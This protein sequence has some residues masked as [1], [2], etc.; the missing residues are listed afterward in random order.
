MQIKKKYARVHTNEIFLVLNNRQ[1]SFSLCSMNTTYKI[2][3]KT[4]FCNILHN[5]EQ[6]LVFLRSENDYSPL[7]PFVT[8]I[9]TNKESI[10]IIGKLPITS[11]F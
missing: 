9:M 6:F 5:G 7:L 10:S 2:M 4:R 8:I 1:I 3:Y 11:M